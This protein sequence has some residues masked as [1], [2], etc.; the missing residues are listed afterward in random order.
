MLI[1]TAWREA[2]PRVE[3]VSR[4]GGQR[5]QPGQ[6]GRGQA[7]LGRGSRQ[8]GTE[9]AAAKVGGRQ[10]ARWKGAARLAEVAARLDGGGSK[11][12]WRRQ[13][14][15]V[16]RGQQAGS[17][18]SSRPGRGRQAAKVEEAAA[19]RGRRQQ[20]WPEGARQSGWMRES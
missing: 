16:E 6:G 4:L 7:R 8:A 11:P 3:E 19:K 14:H 10:Q 1:C 17:E 15:K 2:Q 18:V 12:R 20:A 5:R 9:E 13:Q